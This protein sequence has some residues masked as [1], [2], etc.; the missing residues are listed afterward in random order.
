M[1]ENKS[2]TWM[3]ATQIDSEWLLSPCGDLCKSIHLPN[4]ECIVLRQNGSGFWRGTEEELR[5]TFRSLSHS[6]HAPVF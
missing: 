1:N 2:F 4:G 3:R 5:R 6:P